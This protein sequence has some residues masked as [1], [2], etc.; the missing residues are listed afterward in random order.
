MLAAM[1][2]SFN[3]NALFPVPGMLDTSTYIS[4][5]P[6]ISIEGVGFDFSLKYKSEIKVKCIPLLKRK[7]EKNGTQLH[8]LDLLVIDFQFRVIYS[9][10]HASAR[11]I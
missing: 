1:F 2:T 6:L 11:L 8:G 9:Q 7:H 4:Q 5:H 10:V 3:V